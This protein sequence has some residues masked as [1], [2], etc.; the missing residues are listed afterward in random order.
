MQASYISRCLTKFCYSKQTP[1]EDVD[2]AAAKIEIINTLLFR[3]INP[4]VG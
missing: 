3:A 4:E 1:V 2:H